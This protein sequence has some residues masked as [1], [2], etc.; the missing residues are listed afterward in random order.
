[1]KSL[2]HPFLH[3]PFPPAPTKTSF[4]CFLRVLLEFLYANMNMYFYSLPPFTEKPAPYI[5]P[6]AF[7][8]E[9]NILRPLQIETETAAMVFF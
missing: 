7:L 4:T 8:T 5:L 9:Q 6:L 3:P 1:M 2:F